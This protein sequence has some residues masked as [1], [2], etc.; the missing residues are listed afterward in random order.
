MLCIHVDI[1]DG[2]YMDV[3]RRLEALGVADKITGQLSLSLFNFSCKINRLHSKSSLYTCTGH[4][5]CL[6][7]ANYEHAT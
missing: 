7:N 3:A 6:Y 1:S 2:V 5:D 4:D